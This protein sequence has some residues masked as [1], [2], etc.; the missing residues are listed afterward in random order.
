MAHTTQTATQ[1]MIHPAVAQA[2]GGGLGFDASL[3]DTFDGTW[4]AY[5][6]AL[7]ERVFGR[8]TP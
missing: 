8:A 4:H 2:R 6:T 5:Q 1:P 7:L 3:L